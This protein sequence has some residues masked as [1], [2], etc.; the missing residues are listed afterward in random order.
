MPSLEP[1]REPSEEPSSVPSSAPSGEPSLLSTTL[2]SGLFVII[3]VETDASGYETSWGIRDAEDTLFTGSGYKNYN[4]YS[5][6]EC[7]DSMGHFTFTVYD[8]CGDGLASNTDGNEHGYYKLWVNVNI[9]MEG[10]SFTYSED[11]SF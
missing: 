8:L 3:E 6:M 7:R 4:Y 11:V 9:V 5:E 1:S 10:A 2:F